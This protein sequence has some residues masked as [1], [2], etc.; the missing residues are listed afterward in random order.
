M[1]ALLACFKTHQAL[2]RL[3]GSLALH[4]HFDTMIDGIADEV[5][6]RVGQIFDHGLVDFGFLTR[7]HQFD[8]LAQ[9]AGQIAGDA[10]IFLEQT[11]NRLHPGLH[12]RVL[13][14]GNQQVKLAHRLIQCMQRFGI[15]LAGQDIGPQA[16]QT[17]LGQSD[18]TR[19]VQDLIKTRGIDPDGV[20][21]HT[22]LGPARI[23]R[24]PT[25]PVAGPTP[26][27]R[28]CGRLGSSLSWHT[29]SRRHGNTS[30]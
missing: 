5:D 17:V 14:I 23:H 30:G 2:R 10:R 11:A 16:G 25:R 26:V 8:I 27:R 24:L 1:I 29:G 28:G 7:Q 13:Q 20:F 18:F 9:L 3:A 12:H 4:R 19:Q 6:Q 15:V 21:T 22:L